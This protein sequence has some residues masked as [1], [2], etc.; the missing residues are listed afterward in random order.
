MLSVLNV[1]HIK[2]KSRFI[3][4]SWLKKKCISPP[5]SSSWRG[6]TYPWRMLLC[7]TGA[8]WRCY[9]FSVRRRASRESEIFPDQRM[10]KRIRI[11][12]KWMTFRFYILCVLIDKRVI[13]TIKWTVNA[14]PRNSLLILH[15]FHFWRNTFSKM[16]LLKKVQ[17]QLY[18]KL[19][20]NYTD[21]VRKTIYFDRKERSDQF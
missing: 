3:L 2:I 5:C 21:E 9:R 10:R 7:I 20:S 8:G 14:D 1:F 13:I 19:I 6:H 11:R 17:G 12:F 15:E 16:F 4:E 18:Q